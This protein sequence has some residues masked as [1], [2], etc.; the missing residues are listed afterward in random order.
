MVWKILSKLNKKSI[1]NSG[2]DHQKYQKLPFS[3]DFNNLAKAYDLR[4]WYIANSPHEDKNLEYVVQAEQLHNELNYQNSRQFLFR[5]A[6]FLLGIE[7]FYM[8]Y[9]M[10]KNYDWQ[11]YHEPKH[12][13]QIY[14]DL[15]EG[16]DEGGDDD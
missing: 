12:N 9:D 2:L 3:Q 8:F 13:I 4:L 6:A 14:G 1:Q 16:G 11:D 5:T 10:P 7:L 15:E